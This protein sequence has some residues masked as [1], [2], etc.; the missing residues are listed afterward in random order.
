MGHGCVTEDDGLPEIMG[1]Q[2]K[3]VAQPQHIL[4]VLLLQQ[5]TFPE[6]CVDE[7]IIVR[8]VPEEQ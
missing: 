4:G 5:N 1:G 7:D 8:F 6:T 3:L 2:Y